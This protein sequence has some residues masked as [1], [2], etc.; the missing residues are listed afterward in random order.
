MS[1]GREGLISY[2]ADISLGNV[3]GY[4]S[5]STQRTS[6]E[7]IDISY[8]KLRLSVPAFLPTKCSIWPIAN[9]LLVS[10]SIKE[11]HP[12]IFFSFLHRTHLN[13]RGLGRAPSEEM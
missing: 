7:G 1:H 6:A 3:I 4:L 13:Y 10:S 9:F 8:R 2:C 5:L 11:K 12:Y